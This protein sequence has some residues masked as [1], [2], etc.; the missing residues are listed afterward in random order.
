MNGMGP[1]PPGCAWSTALEAPT[2]KVFRSRGSR[3]LSKTRLTRRSIHKRLRILSFSRSLSLDSL[4]PRLPSGLV[5]PWEVSSASCGDPCLVCSEARPQG[6]DWSPRSLIALPCSLR[7]VIRHRRW[8]ESAR[9]FDQSSHEM[10]VIY[11]IRAQA[12]PPTTCPWEGD[13]HGVHAKG[14]ACSSVCLQRCS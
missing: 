8:D 1:S 11:A 12:D 13:S 7:D 14:C 3:V 2:E 9:I 6:A 5:V 4:A 10:L